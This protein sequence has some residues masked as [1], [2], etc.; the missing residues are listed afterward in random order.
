M[1]NNVKSFVGAAFI[2]LLSACATVD[3]ESVEQDTLRKQFADPSNGKSGLYIYRNSMFG[4]AIK[5][6]LTVNGIPAGRYL[7]VR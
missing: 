5:K 7:F 1:L 6:T 4:A 3:M 2:L